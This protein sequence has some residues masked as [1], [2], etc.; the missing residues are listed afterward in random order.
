MSEEKVRY[1]VYDDG[2]NARRIMIQHGVHPD[3]CLIASKL[4]PELNVY[5]LIA[6]R[7]IE[8]ERG[9]KR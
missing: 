9:D 8:H 4:H 7:E 3:D 6:I 2:T 5:G 1:I